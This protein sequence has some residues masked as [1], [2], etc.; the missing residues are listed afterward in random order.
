MGEAGQPSEQTLAVLGQASN[1]LPANV[2][3]AMI[4]Q[5]VPLSRLFTETSLD[6]DISWPRPILETGFPDHLTWV[7]NRLPKA[8]AKRDE[9][10]TS[11]RR[12]NLAI[13]GKE[14]WFAKLENVWPRMV[15]FGGLAI[16]GTALFLLFQV[17][18]GNLDLQLWTLV[19]AA[20]FIHIL[21][22]FAIPVIRSGG[23]IDP[24]TLLNVAIGV[25]VFS[26]LWGILT[27]LTVTVPAWRERRVVMGG[28]CIVGTI[29]PTIV[30][31]V[32][33]GLTKSN[34]MPY[35][36]TLRQ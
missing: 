21:Q 22:L 1:T 15:V 34:R 12:D 13:R 19:G 16:I 18:K 8:E 7:A 28:L 20:V 25:L 26:V 14:G 35:T 27:A 24:D 10:T 29:V 9:I 17:F 3:S 33:L 4:E 31:G 36:R 6:A 30:G 5:D 23:T 2:L 32:V 11:F